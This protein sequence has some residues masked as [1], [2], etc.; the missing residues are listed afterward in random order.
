MRFLRVSL[1]VLAGSLATTPGRPARAQPGVLAPSP[2]AEQLIEQGLKLREEG[3]DLE[4]L[5][6]FQRAN[7]LGAS[8]RA[9]AQ[10][11]L[12][13]QAL[14]NWVE[15]ERGLMTALTAMDNPWVAQ[16]RTALEKALATVRNQLGWLEVEANVQGAEVSVNETLVGIAPMAGPLRVPAG[17]VNLKVTAPAHMPAIRLVHVLAGE[18][19]HEVLFLQQERDPNATSHG[20]DRAA[21][22][23]VPETGKAPSRSAV[24]P[25]KTSAWLA[26]GG[27]ATFLTGGAVASAVR[28]SNVATWN[29]TAC[30]HG[31]LTREDNCSHYQS[32][33]N[34]AE[35][36]A[37]VGYAAGGALALSSFILFLRSP[38]E[39]TARARAR[40]PRCGIGVSTVWCAG[41]F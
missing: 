32:A 13:N 22:T 11:A 37:V 19:A 10:L 8:P 4:A 15:A 7:A 41:T 12:A 29:S 14:G 20:S 34:T 39:P 30:L 2:E 1:V 9:C 36:F 24:A 33:A 17:V 5:P 35:A 3:K 28:E 6:L 21:E 31:S 38:R 23:T 25:N 40:V 18:H 27:S 26:L 16:R